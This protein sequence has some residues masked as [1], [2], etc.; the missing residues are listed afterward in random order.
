MP[1]TSELLEMVNTVNPDLMLIAA[2][3]EGGMEP[4][5]AA[6]RRKRPN[7]PLITFG[8]SNDPELLLRL[9]RS[10]VRDHLFAPFAEGEITRLLGRLRLR[11]MI[12]SRPHNPGGQ[13]FAF[14]PAKAGAGTSTTAVNVSVALSKMV[15]YRT[16]LMDADLSSGMVRFLLNLELKQTLT[17]VVGKMAGM[18]DARWPDL[19]THFGD[20]DV[21]PSDTQWSS[22]QL[23]ARHTA[24]LCTFAKSRYRSICAD[25]SGLMEP[26]ANEILL[27]A[28]RILLV[29]TPELP[30]LYLASQKYAALQEMDLGSRVHLIISRNTH[31]QVLAE[32]Q[33]EQIVGA[34]VYY[35]IEN[36]PVAVHEALKIGREVKVSSTLGRQYL[37]LAQRLVNLQDGTDVPVASEAWAFAPS[38]R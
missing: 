31:H 9:M 15:G 20:L 21:L 36:N 27:S 38:S 19:V 10:G 4:A 16:L 28:K 33:I 2:E 30:S 7:L 22:G 18:D 6:L 14:L 1:T 5:I 13:L 37:W 11:G 25:L 34:P 35:T 32:Q 29:T 23:D 24:Q 3:S 12:E 26:F 8:K 17:D